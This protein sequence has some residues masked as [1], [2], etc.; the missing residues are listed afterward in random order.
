MIQ[1][2]WKKIAHEMFF[3]QHKHVN[4]IADIVQV[5]RQTIANYLKNC[6][7][8]TAEREWRMAESKRNKKKY[9]REYQ[10]KRRSQNLEPY[11]RV[12]Q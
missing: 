8:Y 6:D 3:L 1:S 4:E 5:S 9:N 11:G 2:E 7:G 12:I 10:A